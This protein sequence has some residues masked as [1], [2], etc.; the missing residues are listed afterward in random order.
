M[1]NHYLGGIGG[2]SG[3]TVE[4]VLLTCASVLTSLKRGVNE[5][6]TQ[7]SGQPW[8]GKRLCTAGPGPGA[9]RLPAGKP[10]SLSPLATVQI[11]LSPSFR[12]G[13]SP[14]RSAR[15]ARDPPPA[16][17]CSWGRL[18]VRAIPARLGMPA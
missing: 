16:A 6:E 18:R 2:T 8:T 10:A 13:Q 14:P 7:L 15:T 11:P 4:T 12:A 3:E 9:S 1:R 17:S 5:K